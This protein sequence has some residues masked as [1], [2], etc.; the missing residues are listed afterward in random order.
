MFGGKGGQRSERSIDIV[1]QQSREPLQEMGVPTP[2]GLEAEPE[3]EVSDHSA[4]QLQEAH[5][6]VVL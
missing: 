4:C 6:A 1:E 2:R 3:E 5:R